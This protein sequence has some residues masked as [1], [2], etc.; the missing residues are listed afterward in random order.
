[1][2]STSTRIFHTAF[3]TFAAALLFAAAPAFAQDAPAGPPPD[4]QQ[5]PNQAPAPQ[6]GWQKF[7]GGSGN[8]SAPPPDANAPATQA[9]ESQ[10][11]PL[12]PAQ[13]SYQAPAI[14]TLPSGTFVTVRIN[15]ALNSDRNQQGDIFSATL[16][17]PVVINGYVVAQSGQTVYGRV[18]EA[19][20]AGRVS[21]VSELKLELSGLTLVDGS[22]LTI[23]SQLV[24]RKGPTSVGR[25][26]AAIGSTTALGAAAGAAA[27]W[28]R[29]AAIGAGAGAAVGIIG[30]LLTRGRPTIVY[31]ESVLTFQLSAPATIDTSHAPAAFQLV[32]PGDYQEGPP[33]NNRPALRYGYGPGYPPPPY[34]YAPAYYPY[35]PYYYSPFFYG[36]A[37][38][39]FYGPRFFY[40]GYYGRGFGYRG[41]RR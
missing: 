35:Y 27:D 12:A 22:N 18:D 28:G 7:G 24:D 6:Q 14:L 38:G 3:G 8:Q 36:P 11:P 5:Q 31:P 20:K 13:E 25:D 41:F 10:A 30:V 26:A 32:Q 17:Q 23:Q 37:F 40:H 1:M 34:A 15:Q 21:G 33:Q 9:P 29:G 16:M 19:K 39:F 2:N 4:N